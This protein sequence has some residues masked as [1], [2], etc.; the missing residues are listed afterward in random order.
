MA[1]VN[2]AILD[3]NMRSSFGIFLITLHISNAWRVHL[4]VFAVQAAACKWE[5]ASGLLWVVLASGLASWL[6]ICFQ[7]FSIVCL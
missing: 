5:Q 3:A 1:F 2:K 7:R 4:L 6:Y